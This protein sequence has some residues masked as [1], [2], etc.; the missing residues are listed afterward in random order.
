MVTTRQSD[1]SVAIMA[2]TIPKASLA[3][4][5]SS[6]KATNRVVARPPV[7]RRVNKY[8]IKKHNTKFTKKGGNNKNSNDNSDTCEVVKM[9]TGTL[10]L[11]RG[12][13][14]RVEFVRKFWWEGRQIKFLQ[15]RAWLRRRT[16]NLLCPL[17]CQDRRSKAFAFDRLLHRFIH[18][19]FSLASLW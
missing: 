4:A 18:R 10:Y 19:T 8:P 9:L 12:A 17:F 13:Q 2:P 11:F 3:K 5:S 1:S 6:A 15:G 7:P 14:R 16:P